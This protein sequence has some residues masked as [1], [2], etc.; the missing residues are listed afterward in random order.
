MQERHA[1]TL[2][3]VL[4]AVAVI[5]MTAT[6]AAVASEPLAKGTRDK[7]RRGGKKTP[8]FSFVNGTLQTGRLGTWQLED[9]TPLKIMPEMEW[10]DERTG[11]AGY[12]ASGREVRLLCQRMGGTLLVRQAVLRS[13]ETQALLVPPLPEL[14]PDEEMPEQPQ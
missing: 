1:R 7:H 10:R 2:R 14:G 5:A 8:R 3:R 12:P 11:S 4:L 13:P 6:I 9:G